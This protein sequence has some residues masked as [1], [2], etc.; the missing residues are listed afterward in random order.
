MINRIVFY[1]K[2]NN[3]SIDFTKLGR[4]GEFF[5]MLNDRKSRNK[6]KKSVMA[7]GNRQEPPY[8]NSSVKRLLSFM[9]LNIEEYVLHL[10]EEKFIREVSINPA[11]KSFSRIAHPDI[12]NVETDIL[13]TNGSEG[14]T[15][16]ILRDVFIIHNTLENTVKNVGVKVCGFQDFFRCLGKKKFKK[17]KIFDLRR[18]ERC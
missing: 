4:I 18:V 5:G 12:Y 16:I 7:K 14:M 13:L 8:R 3:Y 9:Q 1:L 11:D 6:I 2:M 10:L 17:L 15:E